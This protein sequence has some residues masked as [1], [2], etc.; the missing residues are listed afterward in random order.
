MKNQTENL[1][2]RIS[3]IGRWEKSGKS[4]I[5]FCKD[6]S[7]GY[8]M[9]HYWKKRIKKTPHSKFIK[10]DPGSPSVPVSGH[11]ELLFANGSRMLF[12]QIPQ[13]DFIK[14]LMS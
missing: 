1:Q 10:L 4:I 6:E 13:A 2:Q 7:I 8:H 5:Q 12:H 9:F 11:C 3:M 14:Q